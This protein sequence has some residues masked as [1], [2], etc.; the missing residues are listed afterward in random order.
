M[1]KRLR[2]LCKN[3]KYIGLNGGSV[4]RNKIYDY[5]ITHV[6]GYC[7]GCNLPILNSFYNSSNP[8]FVQTCTEQGAGYMAEGYAKVSG[9]PGVAITTSGPGI[10]NLVTS[11]YDANADHVPLIAISGQVG[12]KRRH[13]E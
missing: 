10:T 1:H 8:K 5:G 9:K 2:F 12:T 11:L 7:G 3:E 13:R 6:F 4:I